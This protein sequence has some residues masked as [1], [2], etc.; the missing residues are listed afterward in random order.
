MAV[1]GLT[2]TAAAEFADDDVTVNAIC[3]GPVSGP[4]IDDVIKNQADRLGTD[5]DEAKQVTFTDDA[6]LGTL[7][8]A[9]D[10]ADLAVY[11]ASEKGTSVTAQDINVDAGTTWY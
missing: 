3:P 6:I 7:V 4:R 1:I 11:L 8:D 10:V 9:R 5:Y 2:R